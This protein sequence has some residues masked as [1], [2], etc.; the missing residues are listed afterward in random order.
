M[1]DCVTRQHPVR[2]YP[3]S[4]S[5]HLMWWRQ[6][7]TFISQNSG[8]AV[9]SKSLPFCGR[10]PCLPHSLSCT[11]DG[12]LLHWYLKIVACYFYFFLFFPLLFQLVT[13]SICCIL[14]GNTL[15]D[16]FSLSGNNKLHVIQR[17][18]KSEHHKN[19]L[20]K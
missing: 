13:C 3:K 1:V 7:C 8:E 14:L 15:T 9:G 17:I 10:A 20:Q 11:E 2:E 12:C 19:G 5:Q 4:H 6:Q 18:S 16:C